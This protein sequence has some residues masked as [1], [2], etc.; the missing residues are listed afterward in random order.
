M[1]SI[2]ESNPLYRFSSK[3][4]K[5]RLIFCDRDRRFLLKYTVLST[6]HVREIALRRAY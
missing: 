3:L 5:E 1:D 2:P 6:W 4:R